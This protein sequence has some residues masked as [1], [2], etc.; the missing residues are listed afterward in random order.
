MPYRGR[1]LTSTTVSTFAELQA[2]LSGSEAIIRLAAGTYQVTSTITI[3]RDVTLT[4][5]VEGSSVVLDGGNA[6][7]VMSIN[8]INS[9]TVQ[10]T[11]LTITNGYELVR[12]AS[13]L[14]VPACWR[15]RTRFQKR[16]LGCA[17]FQN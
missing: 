5:D 2:A 12:H 17:C 3:S 14:R 16:S 11:G 7:R 4:A 9:W 6:R 1:A 13:P 10:L 8:S 15:T